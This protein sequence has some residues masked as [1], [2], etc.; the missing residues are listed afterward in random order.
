MDETM[1]LGD[2]VDGLREI[3]DRKQFRHF[4][5]ENLIDLYEYPDYKIHSKL[6]ADVAGALYNAI[7]GSTDGPG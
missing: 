2:F 1:K 7:H 4:V 5:D 3:K 6:K